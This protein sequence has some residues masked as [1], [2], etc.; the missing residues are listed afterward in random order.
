MKITHLS[1]FYREDIIQ[2]L[3]KKNLIGVE[4]GGA[5]GNFIEYF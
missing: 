4:L 1:K 2:L 5:R 3:K